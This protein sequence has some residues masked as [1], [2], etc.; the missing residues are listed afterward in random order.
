MTL[1]T[2]AS[3]VRAQRSKTLAKGP[4]EIGVL[5]GVTAAGPLAHRGASKALFWASFQAWNWFVFCL[6]SQTSAAL[7]CIPGNGTFLFC[8][9]LIC[10]VHAACL[11]APQITGY[12]HSQWSVSSQFHRQT[13]LP[14]VTGL[15]WG[16]LSY[17][18]NKMHSGNCWACRLTR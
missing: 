17:K 8:Y 7:R 9:I 18:V 2:R 1:G 3:G 16:S 10:L 6:F 4:S 13:P 12:H 15:V 5:L 14:R 11:S